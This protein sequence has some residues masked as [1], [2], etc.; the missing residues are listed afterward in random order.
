VT[1]YDFELS[2]ALPPDDSDIDDLADRLFESGCD[3]A[4]LGVGLMGHVALMFTRESGS[5]RDAVL[6]ALADVRRAIPDARLEEA[7][8][9]LVGLTDVA[10]LLHVTRQNV[11]KLAFSGRSLPPTP[12]HEGRPTIWHLST[13]LDWLQREKGY[14]VDDRLVELSWTTMQVNL[15]VSGRD[16]DRHAQREILALLT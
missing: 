1:A 5:A 15:A 10:D 11:R 2:F 3:D 16:A 12:V 13:M 4:T 8:P 14:P 9:D 7:G 6:G